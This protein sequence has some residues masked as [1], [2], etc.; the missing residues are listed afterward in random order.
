LGFS[1]GTR[2]FGEVTMID[3]RGRLTLTEGQAIHDLLLDLFRAGQRRVVLNLREVSYLDSSGLGQLVRG[4]FTAEKHKAELKA[5]GLNR[6]VQEVLKL[7]NL[8]EMFSDYPD[9][10]AALGSFSNG[11]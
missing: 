2:Q 1:A 5:I 7:T 3:V 10:Q 9:E 4:L 11:S 8:Y 6:R